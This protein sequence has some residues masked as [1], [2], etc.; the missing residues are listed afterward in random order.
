VLDEHRDIAL[1]LTDVVMPGGMDGLE[2]VRKVRER[3]PGSKV[4]YS[5]GYAAGAMDRNGVVAAGDEF[6]GK[7]YQRSDLARKVRQ[8]LDREKKENDAS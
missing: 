1:I 5:S 4:L 7:P 6:L 2:L 8:I 3:S